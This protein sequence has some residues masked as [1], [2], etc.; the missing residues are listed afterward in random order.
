[1]RSETD[2]ARVM[3]GRAAVAVSVMVT[4]GLFHAF[5]IGTYLPAK[6][7]T[8]YYSFFSDITMPFGI[9][10]M[11]CIYDINLKLLR[12]WHTK[13]LLVFAGCAAT[14]VAQAFGVYL[15]G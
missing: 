1:M 15:L 7:Y 6:W 5:R 13:A 4:I 8:L 11:L 3:I 14:E 10:F 2:K 12:G 9:Y